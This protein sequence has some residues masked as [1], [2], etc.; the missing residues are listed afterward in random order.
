LDEH[1]V[2]SPAKANNPTK[3]AARIDPVRDSNAL[4]TSLSFQPSRST[5]R[6]ALEGL[7]TGMPG[8]SDE[9]PAK[10]PIRGRF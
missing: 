10:N 1:A 2:A 7:A 3:S 5:S 4:I 6:P 9:I 8:T